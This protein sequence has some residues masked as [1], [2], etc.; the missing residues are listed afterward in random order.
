MRDYNGDGKSDL[1]WRSGEV[2]TSVWHMDTNAILSSGGFGGLSSVWQ[3]GGTGDFNGDGNDD[4]LWRDLSSGATA[5]WLLEPDGMTLLEDGS[6]G[7]VALSWEVAAIDDFNG[8][9]K[10]DI[11][12][13]QGESATSIWMLDGFTTIESGGLGPVED[14]WALAGSGDVDGDGRADLIWRD[15]TSGAT[16]VWI[17]DGAEVRRRGRRF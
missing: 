5:V 10:G 12:W 6:V 11:F 14:N 1:L 9:G 7:T 13:G 8:D 15:Q 16:V 3:Y 4:I 2:A 17:L